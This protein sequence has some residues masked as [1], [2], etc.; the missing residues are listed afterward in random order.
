MKS[1]FGL[2]LMFHSKEQRRTAARIVRTA[3]RR[4]TPAAVPVCTGSGT[5]LDREAQEGGE[6]SA[7]ARLPTG[8][9]PRDKTYNSSPGDRS[10]GLKKLNKAGITDKVQITFYSTSTLS[11]DKSKTSLF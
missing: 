4:E 8:K 7:Q 11:I 6:A 3:G 10:A 5:W 1:A 9:D 2:V